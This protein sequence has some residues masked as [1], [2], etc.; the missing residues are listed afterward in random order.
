MKKITHSAQ[1]LDADLVRKMQA[2]L[3]QADLRIAKTAK[4]GEVEGLKAGARAAA[5]D[6]ALL[7]Q[8][9]RNDEAATR[10]AKDRKEQGKARAGH[11]GTKGGAPLGPWAAKELALGLGK[12]TA[13]VEVTSLKDLMASDPAAG[14]KALT[15]YH[16]ALA[17]AYP[18]EGEIEPPKTLAKYFN[19]ADIDWDILMFKAGG[20]VIGGAHVNLFKGEHGRSY[21][22]I[23]QAWM[24]D[25]A[26]RPQALAAFEQA[27]GALADKGATIVFS[28]INDPRLMDADKKAEDAGRTPYR[29]DNAE[30]MG[31]AG[32]GFV[33]PNAKYMQPVL[34]EGDLPVRHLMLG[35]RSY[36]GEIK[37]TIPGAV[38]RDLVQHYVASFQLFQEK[39]ADNG[40]PPTELVA[41]DSTFKEIA[42]SAARQN[43]G[44]L[45]L[46]RPRSVATGA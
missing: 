4:P 46:D 3:V 36:D 1:T 22:G 34:N 14:K 38:Y 13:A 44:L 8:A 28:E 42:G 33:T 41:A 37:G 25:K 35:L 26:N 21:G 11:T 40:R 15:S 16:R 9:L 43:L 18:G 19:R 29:A 17:V 31:A 39:A 10:T 12:E 30:F 45:P 23:E 5:L 20:E 27:A 32:L 6:S 7:E 2:D 24:S